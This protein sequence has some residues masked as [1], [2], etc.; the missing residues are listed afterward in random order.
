MRTVSCKL[1]P[2]II[3]LILA[4]TGIATVSADELYPTITHVFF[5][6]DGKPFNTT[7]YYTVTC[8]GHRINSWNPRPEEIAAAH[9]TPPENVYSYPATCD[10]YGCNVYEPY[11]LNYR[12]TE[13]CDLVGESATLDFTIKNFSS[14]PLPQDC[15]DVQ[16]FGFHKPS[17]APNPLY[18]TCIDASEPK[19]ESCLEL[20]IPCVS[21]GSNLCRTVDNRSLEVTAAS[22]ACFNHARNAVRDC[23]IWKNRDEYYNS[24]PAYEQCMDESR[25]AYEN[26]YQFLDTCDPAFKS[27]CG[28]WIIGG[29]YVKKTSGW[30][31]CVDEISEKRQECDNYLAP[32]DSSLITMWISPY[33][34]RESGEVKRECIARFV[35]PSNTIQSPQPPVVR[36]TGS[37]VESVV[38]TDFGPRAVTTAKVID[39]VGIMYCTLLSLFGVKC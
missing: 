3:I 31:T 17:A 36:T 2:W 5:E 8:Y 34:G 19:S 35:I 9:S 27:E 38:V 37:V 7:V 23:D 10:H 6:K 18:D 22:D 4:V 16:Q 12:I 39:P 14:T 30:Q 1:L 33:T 26:C 20:M 29:R 11:Y 28:N 15:T 32:V 13:S 21:A 25:D 24:T